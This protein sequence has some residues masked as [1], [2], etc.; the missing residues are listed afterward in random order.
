MREKAKI[1]FRKCS[2]CGRACKG[3]KCSLHMDR[4]AHLRGKK[5]EGY[6]RAP[7]RRN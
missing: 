2:V 7:I 1:E 6:P 3:E 4:G 5:R